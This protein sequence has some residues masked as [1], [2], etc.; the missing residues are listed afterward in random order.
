MI[1]PDKKLLFKYSCF[2]FV[3]FICNLFFTGK[4]FAVY[5][6]VN[7]AEQ[8]IY[9]KDTFSA[10]FFLNTDNLEINVID[11]TLY[12]SPD[13]LEVTDISTANSAFVLWAKTP[14]ITGA[15][16]ISF[17]GGIPGGLK[18]FGIPVL[19]VTFKAKTAGNA[20]LMIASPSFALQGDGKGTKV[21]ID[22]MRISFS[23]LPYSSKLYSITS[24]TQP[25]QNKWYKNNDVSISVKSKKD[26][27]YSY[28][29]S[30]N[31]EIIPDMAP[32]KITGQIKY[33]D[34][35]DGIY[36][37]K[38]ALP[39]DKI[40]Q[41]VGVY[42]IQID[43]TAP[44][45]LSST[46]GKNEDT[47]NGKSFLNFFAVDKTSGIKSYQVKNGYFGFYHD[48]VSPY[49]LERHIFGNIVYIKAT[50]MAGNTVKTNV[51]Y[52]GYLPV[53]LGYILLLFI[54]IF[55]CVIIKLRYRKFLDFYLWIKNF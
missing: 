42:R 8:A 11:A 24:S 14:S 19:R 18:G 1:G 55:I 51:L 50:D 7:V 25:D 34:L 43:N 10:D 12:Y 4:V 17:T 45:F 47:F 3:F 5:M 9:E 41:E 49:K 6:S 15:G 16:T 35:P 53:W 23:V 44:T 26:E 33:K 27:L 32:T 30:T 2:L 31:P 40:L 13:V 39:V 48:A 38:L 22:P 52:P 28:S 54:I 46:I 20:E 21:N 36:Y 37:F 29:F